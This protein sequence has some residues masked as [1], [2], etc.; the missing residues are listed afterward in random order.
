MRQKLRKTEIANMF[1]N[2][3]K[4]IT[5]QSFLM[6]GFYGYSK[7]LKSFRN[8]VKHVTAQSFLVDGFYGYSKYLKSFRNIVKHITAQ[9]FLVDGFCGYS[10]YL[11]SFSIHP[12]K[13]TKEIHGKQLPKCDF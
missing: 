7:Y 8:I 1:R 4:H 2:I 12:Y 5:D 6:D 10:K 13:R 3:V 9:S 11:R